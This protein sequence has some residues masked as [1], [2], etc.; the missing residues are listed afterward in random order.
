MLPIRDLNRSSTTPHINR[1]LLISNIIVFTVFWLSS[2]GIL[3]G[4]AFAAENYD[5]F[6]MVPA[7][8]L[9][10]QNL[11]TIFTSMFM[12]AGWLHLLG[13]MLFLYI[14]GDN[15]EDA[16]GHIGYFFVYIACGLAATFAYTA[17]IMLAPLMNS[18]FGLALSSDL[19][20]GVLGASGAISGVLGAYLVLYPRARIVTLV[21]YFAL[22][23]P[24][25]V[26]LGV[27]F[28]MQWFYGIFDVSGGVAYSA[29]IGGFITGAILGLM[30]REK[31]K[32]R[33]ENRY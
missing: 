19:T 13:N 9:V 32:R 5:R 24:A 4:E 18:L 31:R 23:L 33:S 7:D 22:P 2:Q 8:F 12:H 14:F 17:S 3:L 26:F 25:V 10:G 21:F 1:I 16:F 30:I 15:I 28:L 27:W 20:I 6:V 11:C 29:H